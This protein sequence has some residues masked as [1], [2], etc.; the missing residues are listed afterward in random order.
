MGPHAAAQGLKVIATFQAG[1][2]R[3]AARRVQQLLA[4]FPGSTLAPR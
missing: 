1:Y 3:G 2:H 4:D